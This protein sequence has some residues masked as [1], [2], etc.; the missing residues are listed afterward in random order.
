M[1]KKNTPSKYNEDVEKL[2]C[3]QEK[4]IKNL[5]YRLQCVMKENRK[6]A[7][8]KHRTFKG[9]LLKLFNEDQISNLVRR[10]SAGRNSVS[11]RWSNS[12]IKKA[13]RLMHFCGKSGYEELLR[14]GLPLPSSRTLRRKIEHID[15]QPEISEYL[16]CKIGNSETHC[17]REYSIA[18]EEGAKKCDPQ[19]KEE[20]RDITLPPDWEGKT[21]H[22]LVLFLAGIHARWKQIV[23][24]EY[25][26]GG[27][28]G[29]LLKPIIL[30]IIF[31]TE[32]TGL[33]VTSGICAMGSYKVAFWTSFHVTERNTGMRNVISMEILIRNLFTSL[34]MSY[35]WL[36]M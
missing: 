24:F 22:D 5:Q 8:E 3:K 27:F 13:L 11:T 19:I 17:D 9:V 32:N 7:A 28:G 33:E 1:E 35:M 34:Q 29:K 20:I 14:Q 31:K 23:W 25:T 36:K 30:Q 16:E 12:T 18:L 21:N 4:K 10:Q 6:L 26:G 15:L 2:F